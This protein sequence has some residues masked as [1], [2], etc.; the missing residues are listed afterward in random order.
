MSAHRGEDAP[1]PTLTASA[2]EEPPLGDLPYGPS[3]PGAARPAVP[4]RPLRPTP[5][6]AGGAPGDGTTARGPE[7]WAR[8]SSFLAELD[9]IEAELSTVRACSP[10]VE[11]PGSGP[12]EPARDELE[13]SPYLDERL[14]LARAAIRTLHREV[15]EM[16][17]RWA[18]M[19]SS[20]D[21][22]ERELRGATEEADHLRSIARASGPL[23][24][25]T[26]P[27]A[28]AR[29]RDAADVRAAARPAP[30]PARPYLL[31]TAERYNRTIGGLKSRRRRLAAWTWAGAAL[32]SAAL[33]TAA[34][35]AREPSPS[36]WLGLLPLIWLVPVPF[37][38]VSFFATQ[39]VLRRNH[40]D[41]P[42]MA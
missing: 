4:R 24:T 16:D 33:G 30:D 2:S 10:G 11:D 14:R 28:A 31:F 22:L 19:R 23:P 3:R 1:S 41:V 32:I 5:D 26:T 18:D 17:R 36:P 34:L 15:R 35:L 38:L 6:E 21:L 8:P 37:F 40:L 29:P 27:E 20:A 13:V 12:V 39:R 25:G 42:E 7:P 9:A